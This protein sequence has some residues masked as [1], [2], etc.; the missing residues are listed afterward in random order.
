MIPTPSA[1]ALGWKSAG[2]VLDRHVGFVDLHEDA[3][4]NISALP[5]QVFTGRVS[6]VV[7]SELLLRVF[8][9]WLID[10]GTDPASLPVRHLILTGGYL[11]PSRKRLLA[12]LWGAHHKLP[13]TAAFAP[14]APPAN[15]NDVGAVVA[16]RQ[17]RM[18]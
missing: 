16:I 15:D 14:A 10:S 4:V 1:W 2:L 9:A 11:S 17:R 5:G 3:L 6:A 13:V 12:R 8:T 18:K 7:G